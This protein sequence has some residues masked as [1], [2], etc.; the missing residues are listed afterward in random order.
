M[1]FSAR[2]R[3]YTNQQQQPQ[4]QLRNLRIEKDR[5]MHL[6]RL[7]NVDTDLIHQQ[8]EM[9][10]GKIENLSIEDEKQSSLVEFEFNSA[11]NSS[12]DLHTA[13]LRMYH[14]YEAVICGKGWFVPDQNGS[15][16]G[17]FTTKEVDRWIVSGF[18]H[19]ECLISSKQTEPFAPV[20]IFNDTSMTITQSVGRWMNSL[21]NLL[22][23]KRRQLRRPLALPMKERYANL[24]KK[25]DIRRYGQPM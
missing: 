16:R 22:S 18:L 19:D 7:E 12:D 5:R 20:G 9:K 6:L 10:F 3:S 1:V 8:I 2:P 15:V 14:V 25:F 4:K 13:L 11:D 21:R 24:E 17:P 23:L